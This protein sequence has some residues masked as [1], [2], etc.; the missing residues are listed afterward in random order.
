MG[1]IKFH[2]LSKSFNAHDLLWEIQCWR[3][4][5]HQVDPPKMGSW[6][7]AAARLPLLWLCSSAE[8]FLALQLLKICLLSVS[9]DMAG[10][11][12]RHFQWNSPHDCS[13]QDLR[14]KDI[15]RKREVC[16]S[17][18][19]KAVSTRLPCKFQIQVCTSMS[20][21]CLLVIFHIF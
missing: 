14:E 15:L 20:L 5:K 17:S 3:Y 1:C 19:G 13:K 16:S 11:G 18:E 2:I 10:R 4:C 7:Q 12:L 8:H 6:A 9:K 21:A